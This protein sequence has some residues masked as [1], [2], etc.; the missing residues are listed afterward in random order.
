MGT[1]EQ[2]RLE[3]PLPVLDRT[4]GYTSLGQAVDFINDSLSMSLI[5]GIDEQGIMLINAPS[6]IYRVDLRAAQ[7]G[8]NDGSGRVKIRI[9]GDWCIS[10]FDEGD[11]RRERH[12]SRESFT[13]H[14]G[15]RARESVRAFYHLKGV[16]LGQTADQIEEN[17]FLR[18][19]IR[20]DYRSVEEAIEYINDRLEISIITGL[21]EQGVMTVNASEQ[22]Y[23]IPLHNCRFRAGRNRVSFLGFG[24]FGG[25]GN[26]VEI[27]CPKGFD[28]YSDRD[29]VR[30]VDGER[31]TARSKAAVKEIIT[32]FEFIRNK[33]R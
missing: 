4:L 15:N 18:G 8:I 25:R 24:L 14:S 23:K 2:Q 7:F 5:L 32:A 20:E 11:R 29:M 26:V 16:V 9:F 19:S 13:T 27:T 22:I 28:R 10:V 12:L 6:A 31:F 30:R 17:A 21:D 1:P 33:V 3:V